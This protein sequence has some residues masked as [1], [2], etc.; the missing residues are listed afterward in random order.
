MLLEKL[1]KIGRRIAGAWTWWNGAARRSKIVCITWGPALTPTRFREALELAARHKVELFVRINT[2]HLRLEH[3]PQVVSLIRAIARHYS[4]KVN[5]V[6][7]LAGP[8]IRTGELEEGAV[9]LRKG[10]LLTLTTRKIKGNEQI[11]SVAY[12]PLP[13]EVRPGDRVLIDD[14]QIEL[15]VLR[16]EAPDVLCRVVRGGVVGERKGVNLPGVP[17]SAPAITKRDKQFIKETLKLGVEAL[18]IS[19]VRDP[20]HIL[21]ARSIVA[22]LN[23]TTKTPEIW[24]KVETEEALAKDKLLGIARLADVVVVA[25]GDLSVEHPLEELAEAELEIIDVAR[26]CGRPVI[27]ATGLMKIVNG[28]PLPSSIIDTFLA[29][30]RGDGVML[31]N[32]TAKSDDPLCAVDWTLRVLEAA[33]NHQRNGRGP[34]GSTA[35]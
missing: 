15:E 11:I 23:R 22:A 35:L 27:V 5:I 2:A 28:R 30:V 3:L 21:E 6:C 20:S 24:T 13:Y 31:T 29:F 34:Y 18:A 25:R 4:V 14:G 26:R 1:R 10:A 17:L 9:E 19:F 8:K 33:R 16:V 7:D 32:E 12:E